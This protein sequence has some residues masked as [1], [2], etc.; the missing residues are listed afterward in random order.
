MP[1][2]RRTR[3]VARCVSLWQSRGMLESTLVMP[4]GRSVGFAA[5]GSDAGTPVVWCHGGPGSRLE[6]AGFEPFVDQLGLRVIGIDRPGYGLSSP[7]PDR[8]IAD[9][10][11]DGL[12]VADAL[13]VQE[14]LAVGVSTGGAYAFALA[15]S[16]PARVRAVVACCA[17]SDVRH[18]P[19]RDSM[20]K[21]ICHDVWNAPDRAAAIEVARAVFGDD[22]SRLMT[23]LDEDL[24]AADMAFIAQAA[25]DPAQEISMQAQFAHGVQG[26]V[27]DRRADGPGWVS[28]D[29]TAVACPVVVLHGREDT[30]VDPV[31]AEHTTSLIPQATLRIEDGHG[32]LSVTATIIEPLMELVAATR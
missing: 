19:S 27:D 6:P 29:I 16:A 11:P 23:A 32:H 5:Y 25:T 3:R 1:A 13:G 4:D 20:N 7:L 24:C 10:V 12:A 26:Y 18:T 17:M 15:A 28:F 31:N 22:G 14:F 9:W 30:I 8:S 21:A 2:P